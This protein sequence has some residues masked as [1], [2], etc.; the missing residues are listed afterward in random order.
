MLIS[1]WYILFSN[2]YNI[3]IF[4]LIEEPKNFITKLKTVP[5]SPNVTKSLKKNRLMQIFLTFKQK[6]FPE[7]I[8]NLL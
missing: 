6:Y 5:T 3:K 8:Q 4:F 1:P 7:N 2:S